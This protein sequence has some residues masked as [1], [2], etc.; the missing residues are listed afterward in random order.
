VDGV[1]QN[2][3]VDLYTV[4]GVPPS[5]VLFRRVV[6]GADRR[7]RIVSVKQLVEAPELGLLAYVD[8]A[9][10]SGEAFVD[11]IRTNAPHE[12]VRHRVSLRPG[13]NVGIAYFGPLDRGGP[14]LIFRSWDRIDGKFRD[15]CLLLDLQ[16]GKLERVPASIL[17]RAQLWGS[18]ALDS[19]YQMM[20]SFTAFEDGTLVVPQGTELAILDLKP[21]VRFKP[22]QDR[23]F[24]LCVNN[25]DYAAVGFIA[26]R[27]FTDG[28]GTWKWWIL[29]KAKKQWHSVTIPG[30]VSSWRNFGPWLAAPVK[31]KI[32][33]S[34]VGFK[35][36]SPEDRPSGQSFDNRAV[37]AQ[38][39]ELL[40]YHVPTRK[41]HR[42]DTKQADSEILYVDGS[43][44]YYRILDQMFTATIKE[45]G[46]SAPQ[47]VVKDQLMLD[48]HWLFFGPPVKKA[49]AK[50]N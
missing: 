50:A 24:H 10:K 23:S 12:R 13:T 4:E 2:Y 21:P 38:T 28:P 48:V 7:G 41:M 32:G 27:Q 11:L 14:G 19:T 20:G 22:G 44:V 49:P 3:P 40:L 25:V 35:D 45:S 18:P 34:I 37:N 26:D 31:G 16:S 15:D 30:V 47:L 36:R 33:G 39:G 8:G 29:E 46:I 6:D 9:D 43:T 1:F 17:A 5:L 42:I